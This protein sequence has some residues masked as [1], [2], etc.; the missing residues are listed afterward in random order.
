[1]TRDA[2]ESVLPTAWHLRGEK[3]LRILGRASLPEPDLVV[4]RGTARDYLGRHPEPADVALVIEVADTSLDDDRDL[5][6]RVYGGGEVALY[7]I[8]NLV[9]GQLEVYSGPSGP[10]EPVGYRHCEVYRPGQ[11]IPL[12]IEGFEAARTAVADLLP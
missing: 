2:L 9:D 12:V 10:S 3:P 11:E 4:A 1:M 7:W 5:M 6:G 8:I